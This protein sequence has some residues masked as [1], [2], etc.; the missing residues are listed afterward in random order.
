VQLD[1]LRARGGF[2]ERDLDVE[3]GFGRGGH[4]CSF[5]STQTVGKGGKYTGDPE[6]P[7]TLRME[8]LRTDEKS[9]R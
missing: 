2:S 1:L 7:Q 8:R 6:D 4:W 5:V 9:I 3:L